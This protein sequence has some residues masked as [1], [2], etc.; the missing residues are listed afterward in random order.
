VADKLLGRQ[1]QRRGKTGEGGWGRSTKGDPASLYATRSEKR[2][3]RR[4]DIEGRVLREGYLYIE[5]RKV[6]Y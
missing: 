5:G 6:G 4:K 2:E 3:E 1:P